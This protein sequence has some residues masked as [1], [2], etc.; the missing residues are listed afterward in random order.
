MAL[1][2]LLP[3]A[4]LV[5]LTGLLPGTT[6]TAQAVAGARQSASSTVASG[7][8][9]VATG[10]ASAPTV[11][12]GAFTI[13]VSSLLGIGGGATPFKVWSTGTLP[14]SAMTIR[15]DTTGLNVIA[16]AIIERCVGG[17]ATATGACTGGAWTLVTYAGGPAVRLTEGLP[18]PGSPVYLRFNYT[19]VLSIQTFT[20]TT[21]VTRADVRPAVAVAS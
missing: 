11:G 4:V 15:L 9:G 18:T 19:G 7:T 13:S 20:V 12:T 17:T 8:W 6:D 1:R 21:I 5:L 10:V 3:A 16:G 14:L 2:R